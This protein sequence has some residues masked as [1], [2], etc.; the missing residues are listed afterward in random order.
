M[1]SVQRV[2]RGRFAVG[3]TA[4]VRQP[5]LRP[6]AWQVTELE[7]ERN[8]TWSTHSPG[9]RMTAGH[10]IESQG[11]GSRVRL[12][13]EL[14]G[15]MAPLVSWLY[16]GLIERYVSTESQGLKKRCESAA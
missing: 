13:F 16:G 12:W 1:T 9:L 8:F 6:A 5:R 15:F 11:A 14:S 3:S 10:A 2:D 7:D 4:H